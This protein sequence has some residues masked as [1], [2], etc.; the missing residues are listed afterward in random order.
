MEL[1]LLPLAAA[2]ASAW[3]LLYARLRRQEMA[4][5]VRERVLCQELED[6]RLQLQ[7]LGDRVQRLEPAVATMRKAGF[8]RPLREAPWQARVLQLARS[9][10]KPQEIARELEL[11]LSQVELALV[12][13]IRLPDE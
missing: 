1:W 11:S 12:F 8:S 3:A 4:A 10:M 2:L 7:C 13:P 6:L 9:G 5:L